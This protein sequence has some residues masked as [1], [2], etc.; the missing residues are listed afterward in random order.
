MDK[1][2][3]GELSKEEFSDKK[4]KI[5]FADTEFEGYKGN[6]DKIDIQE[7]EV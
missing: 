7:F 4:S 6:D 2:G 5:Y 3:S 1:D